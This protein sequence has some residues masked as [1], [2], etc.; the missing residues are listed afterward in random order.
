MSRSPPVNSAVYGTNIGLAERDFEGNLGRAQLSRH[1]NICC[2][3]SKQLH[4]CVRRILK[5]S[6]AFIASDA[7]E[8]LSIWT[9]GRVS[10]ALSL[11]SAAPR[12]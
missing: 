2:W 8:E 5:I 9:S 12:L 10:A 11:V 6:P 3:R 1:H 4:V 7:L